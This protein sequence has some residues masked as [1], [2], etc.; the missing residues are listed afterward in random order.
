MSTPIALPEPMLRDATAGLRPWR[1]ADISVV[2]AMSRD[3][4]VLRFTNVPDPYGED[5]AGIWLALQPARLRAGDGAAFA[6]VEPP[7]DRPLGAIGVRVLHG[8]GIAEIG[9]HLA[10]EARGRGLATAALRLLSV[11]SLRTLPVARLQLTTHLDNPASQR[12]AEKAGYTREAVLR[13]WADQR[14]TRVDLIMYSLLRGD[15]GGTYSHQR[16]FAQVGQRAGRVGRVDLAGQAVA[17]EDRVGDQARGD[18]VA[19]RVHGLDP[20]ALERL[21]VGLQRAVE[22]VV[23]QPLGDQ[24]DPVGGQPELG[25]ELVARRHALGID[26]GDR[27]A[28]VG[29]DAELV[30][31]AAQA[32]ALERL[33]AVV[34]RP[35]RKQVTI[36]TS[37]PSARSTSATPAPV[38]YPS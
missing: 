14:G 20:V 17:V 4:D 7:D 37:W 3:P 8:R 27:G 15:V 19:D 26:R 29:G 28:A 16:A 34:A 38:K 30:Q 12:V 1:E 2:V 10:P 13:A 35:G 21:R 11:W 33:V 31:A 32:H 6:I 5:D 36:V 22:R 24:H 23:G 18:A 9:Y 25:A